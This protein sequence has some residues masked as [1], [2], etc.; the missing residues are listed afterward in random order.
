MQCPSCG[1][2]VVDDSA[3]CPRCAERLPR[4]NARVIEKNEQLPAEQTVTTASDRADAISAKV[5]KGFF[6]V[7]V[8]IAAFLV[9]VAKTTI[10]AKIAIFVFLVGCLWILS[11][12]FVRGGAFFLSWL[13][14]KLRK[15]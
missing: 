15:K 5:A 3:Y 8:V 1:T 6:R 9:I 2:N 13:S 7:G 12:L 11:A 10:V 4:E 14:L